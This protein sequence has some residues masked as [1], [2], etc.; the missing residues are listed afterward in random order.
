M[1]N[2]FIIK[3]GFHSKGDSQVSGSLY[4]SSSITSTFVGDGSGLTSLPTQTAN[5]FT[6]TLKNKLDAIEAS[7]DVTDATNVTA[8][9][10]L[11]DSEV[12]NLALVKA[13]A[14]GVSNGNVLVANAAVA[15]NDFLKIDGTSVEGRTVAQVL[16]DLNVEAGADVTDA[17]NVLSSLP[18]GVVSS[19]TFPF[20]GD[21]QITGS[22]ILSGSAGTVFEVI[23]SSGS[24]F[25]ITDS[26]EGTLFSVAD[27]SG[28]PQF[29]V[30]DAGVATIGST[31]VSIYTTAQIAS[32]QATT[33]ESVYTLSSSSFDGAWFDYTIISS[34]N[35]RA[36]N[37]MSIWEAGT[38]NINF[39]ETT[40]TDIGDT[41]G[42]VI[43]TVITGSEIAL[44]VNT[45]TDKW[46]IKT[47]VRS[48]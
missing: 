42:V 7:A 36:G 39:T 4:V 19:S 35:M 24:L 23:G 31:P 22:L 38:T 41:T 44:R 12:T 1:A 48:I 20:T 13:L 34:S 47:I 17:A 18:A 46:K 14:S 32:T 25:E 2:E 11:M 40:T 10:A 8:A 6:T 9:G 30:T 45:P 33:N 43:S 37:V 29:G 16:S 27:I 28:I 5:D 3:N 26:F 15:D 21:A